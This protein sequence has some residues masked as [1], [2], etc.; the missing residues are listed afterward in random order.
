[1]KRKRSELQQLIDEQEDEKI[2]LQREIEKMS[3]RLAQI[4]ASLSQMTAARSKYDHTI[5]ETE[6]AYTKVC[7]YTIIFY[8]ILDFIKLPTSCRNILLLM[9]PKGSLPYTQETSTCSDHE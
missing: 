6:A 3:F 9:E 8:Q 7:V 5:A 2:T 1:M 4:N